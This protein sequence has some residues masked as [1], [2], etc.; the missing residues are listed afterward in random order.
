M[1]VAASQQAVG[2]WNAALL[3]GMFI[4]TRKEQLSV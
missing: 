4:M 2:Q 1:I 3:F